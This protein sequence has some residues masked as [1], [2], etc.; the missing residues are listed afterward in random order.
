MAALGACLVPGQV[1]RPA[2][3]DSG[4][5]KLKPAELRRMTAAQFQR[6]LDQ[7][8]AAAF[9]ARAVKDIDPHSPDEPNYDI[10]LEH[11]AEGSSGWLHIASEIGPYTDPHFSE[12]L[13]VAL[14]DALVA[15][16]SGVLR[17]IGSEPHFD[18]ACGY[19]FV[20]QTESYLQ[21]HQKAALAALGRVHSPW[22]KEKKNACRAQLMRIPV[23]T[24]SGAQ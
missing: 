23:N 18:Q 14:A 20:R 6:H 9:T 19:P 10:I 22:L 4:V 16:P 7:E 13:R 21:R 15:N 1:F 17:L 8:G 3:G 24:A 5:K 12:G 2:G 11:I